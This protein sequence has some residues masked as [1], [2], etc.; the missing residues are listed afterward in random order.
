MKRR[1]IE[2][3]EQALWHEAMRGVA[4]D[5]AAKKAVL[6][7]K[8]E[9]LPVAPAKAAPPVEQ[10]AVI[11]DP[12]VRRDDDRRATLHEPTPGLDRRQALRLK[13]GQLE[14]EARLDL[15]GMVQTEAHRELAGFIARCY[16]AGKR[17]LLVVTGKGTREGSGVLRAAVPRW[18]AEPALR[19]RVLASAPAQ[20]RDGGGGALYILLRRAR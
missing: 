19:D 2:P 13:R 17:T 18:L 20:P 12:G 7:P 11:L 16:A 10:R 15:H 8:I 3:D 4:R 1:A 6:E 14:I 9:K 5:R